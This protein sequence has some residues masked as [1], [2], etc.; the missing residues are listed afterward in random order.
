MRNGIRGTCTALTRSKPLL[1]GF[2]IHGYG[3]ILIDCYDLL[4]GV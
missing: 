3:W 2:V 1:D 4:E